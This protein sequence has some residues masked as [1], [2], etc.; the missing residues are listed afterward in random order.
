DGRRGATVRPAWLAWPDGGPR[1]DGYG[2]HG[3][4]L[5]APPL[6]RARLYRDQS[7]LLD[8]RDLGMDRYRPR[9]ADRRGA[10]RLGA[11]QLLAGILSD[12]PSGPLRDLGTADRSSDLLAELCLLGRQRPPGRGPMERRHQLRRRDRLYLCRLDHHPHPQHLSEVLRPAR[13][14]LFA[15]RLVR[16]DGARRP[17][18]WA[19]LQAAGHRSG[20]PRRDRAADRS[21]AELHDG[22]ER[23]LS[24]RDGTAGL[25]VSPNRRARDVTN[26]GDAGE[27]ARAPPSFRASGR[28]RAHVRG[29]G[30]A[31]PGTLTPSARAST[32]SIP[33]W[34]ARMTPRALS[35]CSGLRVACR[36]T[37]WSRS[38]TRVR[39][40][41][42]LSAWTEIPSR[43]AAARRRC[44]N[45][46][47]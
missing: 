26:D 22:L 27:R 6:Q 44:A 40:C 21:A 14:A 4:A 38:Q 34:A 13:G 11:V 15:R 29:C 16:G 24:G 8:G 47:S 35:C 37:T 43:P 36:T 28:R 20:A 2:E 41:A 18:D 19:A 9:P 10:R 12:Q 31:S 1:R 5:L 17:A 25:A 30:A 32:R 33:E 39:A 45:K 46:S 3:G 7:Q 42:G 23:H